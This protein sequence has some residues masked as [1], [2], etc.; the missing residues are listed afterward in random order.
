MGSDCVDG[1]SDASPDCPC[2]WPWNPTI[3]GLGFGLS[4]IVAIYRFASSGS[5]IRE[6]RAMAAATL[7]GASTT[8]ES[9]VA[10]I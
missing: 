2:P 5:E 3:F 6:S 10:A 7:L 4:P 9:M 8:G 1:E